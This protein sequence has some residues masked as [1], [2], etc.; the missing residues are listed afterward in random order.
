MT[1][2]L[3][4]VK[5]VLKPALIKLLDVLKRYDTKSGKCIIFSSFYW[6][7]IKNELMFQLIKDL[8]EFLCGQS[9]VAQLLINVKSSGRLKLLYIFVS[10]IFYRPVL[11]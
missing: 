9:Q 10:T 8:N 1:F 11:W 6:V 3:L 2:E 4:D 5:F 7:K